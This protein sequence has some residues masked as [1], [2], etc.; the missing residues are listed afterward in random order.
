LPTGSF[1]ADLRPV[2]YRATERPIKAAIGAGWWFL[3]GP[4]LNERMSLRTLTLVIAATAYML[5]IV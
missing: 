5:F 1:A 4:L 3:L 2:G